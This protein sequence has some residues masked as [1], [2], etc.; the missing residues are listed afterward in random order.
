MKPIVHVPDTVLTTP[1]Q[2]VAAFDGK[3]KALVADMKK[4]L[5]AT[6][7]PTGVG[8]AAPQIGISRQVFITKPN[9][10]SDIRVFINPVVLST[11]VDTKPSTKVPEGKLEGCLSIPHIWGN[12]RRA[13]SVTLKYQDETGTVHEETFTEFM[14]TIVQHE[15]DHLNGILYTQR[16]LEQRQKLYQEA[17]DEKG[18][19]I[20][21]EIQIP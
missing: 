19:E 7:N 21:E 10:K 8:L 11:S 20:L 17:L 3:L 14:A 15:T 12:V 16:V 2:P 6:K 9:A 18:K 13:P 1:A 4:S 5:L